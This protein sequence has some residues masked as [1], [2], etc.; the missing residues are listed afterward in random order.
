MER[1]LEAVLLARKLFSTQFLIHFDVIFDTRLYF[2]WYVLMF[3]STKFPIHLNVI[4]NALD[5]N[6]ALFDVISMVFDGVSD[7][8]WCNFRRFLPDL[9]TFQSILTLFDALRRFSMDFDAISTLFDAFWRNFDVFDAFR[10]ISTQFLD[11]IFD[12]IFDAVPMFFDVILH[13]ST[14]LRHDF[15]YLMLFALFLILSIHSF[16]FF[17]L[18]I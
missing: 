4:F 7:I 17:F 13:I 6:S 2:F 16:F 15:R 3:F 12:T 10:R 5:I 11:T 1:K 9:D 18:S 14:G 8:F